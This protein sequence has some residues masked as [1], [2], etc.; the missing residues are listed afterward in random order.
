MKKKNP[1]IRFKQ[2]IYQEYDRLVWVNED[3]L[4]RYVENFKE[5]IEEGDVFIKESRIINGKTFNEELI[6]S[7]FGDFEGYLIDEECPEC[8]HL[9]VTPEGG[10]DSRKFCS[11]YDCNYANEAFTEWQK[12]DE[13]HW[14][15]LREA[16]PSPIFREVGLDLGGFIEKYGFSDIKPLRECTVCLR[17]IPINDFF[18]QGGYAMI[19]YV[20]EDCSNGGPCV[21]IPIGKEKDKWNSILGL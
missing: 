8:S 14:K 12:E 5:D 15:Q 13:L 19:T 9:L 16:P 21:A 17:Q 11:N 18:V 3:E 1:F 10:L 2:H 20:H 4:D 6:G 7:V